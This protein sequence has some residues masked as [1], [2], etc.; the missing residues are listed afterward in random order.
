MASVWQEI[1]CT[2]SGGGCGGFI[3]VKLSMAINRRVTLICPKCKHQH[4]RCIKDGQVVEQGRFQGDSK[5]EL[6]PTIA[7]WSKTP[8]TKCMQKV[9]EEGNFY[10]ERDGVVIK[11]TDDFIKPPC[12]EAQV[13][14]RE[15]FTDRFL[16][17]LVG[18]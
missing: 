7:A 6:C 8:K 4:I 12:D 2:T 1:H 15:S 13:I 14:L 3:L 5:E 18:Q 10:K 17:R 11:G 16:G 9:V